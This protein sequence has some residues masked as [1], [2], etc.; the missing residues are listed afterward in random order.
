MVS[1][2]LQQCLLSSSSHLQNRYRISVAWG[3]KFLAIQKEDIF[4]KFS[5]WWRK[6]TILTV[7]CWCRSQCISTKAYCQRCCIDRDAVQIIG[8]A[9]C[10]LKSNLPKKVTFLPKILYIATKIKSIKDGHDALYMY[11]YV[12]INTKI[13]CKD[14]EA[15]QC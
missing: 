1:L 3:I 2:T 7:I 10:G 15:P 9:L 12:L 14:Y 8:S 13:A 6:K 11:T 5:K 4:C